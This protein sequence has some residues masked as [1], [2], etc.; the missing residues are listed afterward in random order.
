[1]DPP[2]GFSKPISMPTA[3]K[4]AAAKIVRVRTASSPSSCPEFSRI[5]LRIE[6]LGEAIHALQPNSGEFG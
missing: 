6:D 4:F 3:S 2:E 5:R 1:P